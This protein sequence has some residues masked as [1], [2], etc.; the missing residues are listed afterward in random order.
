MNNLEQRKYAIMMPS[1]WSL[2][3]GEESL[4]GIQLSGARSMILKWLTREQSNKHIIG[5]FISCLLQ[6]QHL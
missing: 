2:K 1:E 5:S 4:P 3:P 6:D